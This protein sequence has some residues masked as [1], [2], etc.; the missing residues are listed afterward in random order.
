MVDEQD[1]IRS[2][3]RIFV[4]RESVVELEKARAPGDEVWI[5]QALSGE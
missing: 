1:G 2:H 4:N 5:F 3:L